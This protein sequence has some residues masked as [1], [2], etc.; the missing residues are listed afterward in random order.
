MKHHLVPAQ[1]H[2]SSWR[3]A[4][5]KHQGFQLKS[6]TCYLGQKRLKGM[7]WDSTCIPDFPMS[8]VPP[9]YQKIVL[10]FPGQPL[11]LV[12]LVWVGAV[13]F[14]PAI[15][16]R[17]LFPLY[18]PLLQHSSPE[19]GSAVELL[20]SLPAG[21]WTNFEHVENRFSPRYL[22]GSF[23]PTLTGC[24]KSCYQEV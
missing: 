13:S 22:L 8:C 17:D 6:E 3:M 7:G 1:H 19:P 20:Q 9:P 11:P 15:R 4:Y 23:L 5:E 12:L 2:D 18:S 16:V 10:Y 21:I 14:S 24:G